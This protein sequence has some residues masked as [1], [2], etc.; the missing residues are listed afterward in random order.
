[1][2]ESANTDSGDG[3]GDGD[4]CEADTVAE[5]IFTDGS[6]RIGDGH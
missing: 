2:T 5:S 1:M 6:D 4:G 3:G